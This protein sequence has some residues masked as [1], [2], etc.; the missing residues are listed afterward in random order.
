MKSRAYVTELIGTFFLVFV[1][2]LVIYSNQT[3]SPF[4]L[5]P[6]A[7]G[8]TLMIMVYMGGHISGGHYNPAV[9]LG[10]ALR[11]KLSFR[12]LFYYIAAQ[13]IGALLAAYLV[14]VIVGKTFS[15]APSIEPIRAL[16][17]EF[18]FTF[19]L[20]IV[21]LNTATN[22]KTDGNSYYGL[23]IGFTIVVGAIAGGGLSGGAYNPAV[24]TGSILIDTIFG[25]GTMKHLWLYLVGP[26]AGG[27]A[28]AAIYRFQNPEVV[29]RTETLKT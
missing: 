1:V 4:L 11:G 22:P 28:A 18:L 9:S 23:A 21:V 25:I 12:D 3:N 26:F 14:Y 29:V 6:L 27:A 20:V 7:I 13:I 15:P 5:G 10:V 19:A 16:V 17:I 2:G 8:C 24:G